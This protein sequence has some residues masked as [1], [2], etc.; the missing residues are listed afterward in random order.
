MLANT[1]FNNISI[2]L[3]WAVLLVEE[4][5]DLPHVTDK[6]YHIVVSST[7]HHDR[8]SNLTTLVVIDTDC[9]GSCKSNY[10]MIT[11]TITF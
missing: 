11:T 2:I 4:T 8:G 10:H 7:P 6:L 3:W 5:T 9:T 1:T